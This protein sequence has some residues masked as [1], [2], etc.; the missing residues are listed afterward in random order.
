MFQFLL[1]AG[2]NRFLSVYVTNVTDVNLADVSEVSNS[3]R[4]K[5]VSLGYDSSSF[6]YGHA[7]KLVNS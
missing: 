4:A 5:E 7:A 6:T 3:T 1:L 2:K